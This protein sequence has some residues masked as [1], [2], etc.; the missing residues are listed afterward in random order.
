MTRVSRILVSCSTRWIKTASTAAQLSH[1]D[2][3]TQCVTPTAH[4]SS[5]ARVCTNRKSSPCNKLRGGLL[6][7]RVGESA[8]H[9]WIFGGGF[10]LHVL[11]RVIAR[12][13]AA[14][15]NSTE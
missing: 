13:R 8:I 2:T 11:I 12:C 6:L 4:G 5:T 10:R 14:A 7:R 3:D 1:R 15:T 9:L